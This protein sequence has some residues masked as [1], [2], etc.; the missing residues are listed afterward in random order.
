[1]K[2]NVFYLFMA[3][4]VITFS[5]SCKKD[6]SVTKDG[7]K[8]G[9]SALKLNGADF[10]PNASC[11]LWHDNTVDAFNMHLWDG[12]L[13]F[14]SNYK[15]EGEGDW[16]ELDLYK[17]GATPTGTYT[18]G[19]DEEEGTFEAFMQLGVYENDNGYLSNQSYIEFIGGTVTV[20]STEDPFTFKVSIDLEGENG[21]ILKGSAT[22]DFRYIMQVY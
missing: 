7:D 15:V 9:S 21:E 10:S 5:P 17:N 6:D 11:E 18:F 13:S 2:K 1:M 4:C 22:V 19:H 3:M 20:E 16:L 12:N 8:T 14:S